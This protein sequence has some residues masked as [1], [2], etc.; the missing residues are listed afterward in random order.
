MKNIFILLVFIVLWIVITITMFTHD[1]DVYLSPNVCKCRK[2]VV[3]IGLP[4]TGTCSFSRALSI[5]GYKVQHF[6]I[7]LISKLNLY[8]MKR[9]ALV[10]L[11]M[12]D[13]T[14]SQVHEMFPEA[15][16]VYTFRGDQEAWVKSMYSLRDILKKCAYYIPRMRAVYNRF[17]KTYGETKSTFLSKKRDYESEVVNLSKKTNISFMDI[18]NQEN[19]HEEKWNMVGKALGMKDSRFSYMRFPNE[20]HIML[21]VKQVWKLI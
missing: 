7:N 21:H 13:I 14:P 2:M 12:L 3:C 5:L 8:K 15:T 9:N 11:T 17:L 4:R 10:D 20:Y 1:T 19:S 16:L 18:T 6:P